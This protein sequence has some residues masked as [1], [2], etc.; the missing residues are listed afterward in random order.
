M[1]KV[2]VCSLFFF[3]FIHPCKAQVFCRLRILGIDPGI[4]IVGFGFLDKSGSK[5]MPVQ[6]G[7]ITT[8]AHQEP[9]VRLKIIYDS[10]LQL[11]E[12][13][14]PD[15]MAVE[16]LY[17]NR[18]VTTAFQVGQARGVIMLAAEKTSLR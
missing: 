14:K 1:G 17:F 2:N 3:Y 18:N 11:I 7:S 9:S 5:L 12:R 16:K 13:Y 15:A 10:L 4:A 8:E 6:Y